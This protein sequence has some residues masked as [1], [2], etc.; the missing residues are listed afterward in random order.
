MART[1]QPAASMAPR[2]AHNIDIDKN[3]TGQAAVHPLINQI[4]HRYRQYPED[5]GVQRQ[6]LQPSSLERQS[7]HRQTDTEHS[8]RPAEH[9]REYRHPQKVE[10]QARL[11]G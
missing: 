8:K 6:C 5:Q 4:A 9:E 3:M 11:Q 7:Q 10:T 1:A 2:K